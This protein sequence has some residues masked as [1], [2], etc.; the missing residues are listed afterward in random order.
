MAAAYS[1]REGTDLETLG[2]IILPPTAGA[3][4]AVKNGS[5]YFS[6]SFDQYLYQSKE[7]PK[8]GFGLFGQAG[9]SD[10]NPNP[11][12]WQVIVGVGG[13]G[14]IP[15]RSRDNWGV[16]FFHYSLSNDLK[17]SL[18]PFIAVG[19]EQGVEIFYNAAVTPW[20]H[21]GAD[22]QI[23]DPVL[24][25]RDTAVFFGLRSVIKF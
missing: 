10:G 12:Q 1:T 21:V 9:V 5:Y 3:T 13:T 16:G 22:L 18:A 25:Q 17:Q 23:I 11:L 15:G 6:Y 24:S 19:D 2:D 4:A 7:N 14:L 20:F 8:E